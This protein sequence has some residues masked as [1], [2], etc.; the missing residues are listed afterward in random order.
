M[1]KKSSRRFLSVLLSLALVIGIIPMTVFADNAE[2]VLVEYYLL[3]DTGDTAEKTCEVVTS[4]TLTLTQGSV[5]D[6]WYVV[7]SE[8]KLEINDRIEVKG[9]VNLVL[10]NT[11]DFCAFEGIHV[12]P[13]SSLTIYR[14]VGEGGYLTADSMSSVSSGCAGI[15]GNNEE[16]NGRITINGGTISV[17]GYEGGA[18]IGSGA[19][20]NDDSNGYQPITING[21]TISASGMYGGAGIGGGDK[22][23]VGGITINGGSVEAYGSTGAAGIGS[24]GASVSKVNIFINGGDVRAIGGVDG[25]GIGTGSE[26]VVGTI[27]INAGKVYAKGSD[28]GPGI[29]GY[30]FPEDASIYFGMGGKGVTVEAVGGGEGGAGVGTAAD[31][32]DCGFTCTIF[33]NADLTLIG[34]LG[35]AGLGGGYKTAV[36]L[37]WQL[38][39]SSSIQAKINAGSYGDTYAEAIGDGVDAGD[40]KLTVQYM[41]YCGVAVFDENGDPVLEENRNTA[42]SHRSVTLATCKHPDSVSYEDFVDESGFSWHNKILDCKYCD[43]YLSGSDYHLPHAFDPQTHTCEC[44]HKAYAV[45]VNGWSRDQWKVWNDETDPGYAAENAY[46]ILY[47]YVDGPEREIH[48]VSATYVD[49]EDGQ[50]KTLTEEDMIISDPYQVDGNHYAYPVRFMMPAADVSFEIYLVMNISFDTNGS[51]DEMEPLTI[52]QGSE[53]EL[54]DCTAEAPEGK[55]FQG[56]TVNGSDTVYASGTELTITEDVVLQAQWTDTVCYHTEFDY[57]ASENGHAKI[58]RSCGVQLG[59]EE[60]H[61][62]DAKDFVCDLCGEDVTHVFF[63]LENDT[64]AEIYKH[65]IIPRGGKVNRPQ[66]PEIDGKVFDKWINVSDGEPF[67]FNTEIDVVNIALAP[68]WDDAESVTMKSASVVFT[69]G[70]QLQFTMELSDSFLEDPNASIEFFKGETKI[71]PTSVSEEGNIRIYRV[72]VPILEF[73]DAVVVKVNPSGQHRAYFY[74]P[75]GETLYADNEFI[76]SMKLYVQDVITSDDTSESMKMLAAHVALYY[77]YAYHFFKGQYGQEGTHADPAIDNFA[78]TEEMLAAYG[79]KKLVTEAPGVVGTSL[80]V[81]FESDNTLRM[82]FKL[83]A[84][85]SPD[86]YTF[87]YSDG[88]NVYTVEPVSIGSNR[89]A[90]LVEDIA[91]PNLGY[92][93]QFTLT[94]KETQKTY[95]VSASVMSYCLLASEKGSEKM[96]GLAK[97]LYC[98]GEAAFAYF[99]SLGQ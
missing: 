57:V 81:L 34:G 66:D 68:I 28:Y 63:L 67:D 37:H 82:S 7:N 10:A 86:D 25:A 46:A 20:A 73:R 40:G 69:A 12:G 61:I 6:G 36:T 64:D 75:D 1:Q 78:V 43:Q 70:L 22:A 85:C 51:S 54:P 4:E 56:W 87:A 93:Y 97:A 18:G 76:Y 88:E 3:G 21:G 27:Q 90:I 29:G 84:G 89:W 33:D 14:A 52:D 95:V 74:H 24:G 50:V 77:Q 38:N 59:A 79:A 31:V 49:P 23:L 55:V 72:D 41:G 9:V 2:T 99:D 60:A 48:V 94:H 32:D 15:G 96:Q 83:D 5:T 39:P 80:N 45:S 30:V 16:L 47:P 91:A 17:R 71:E 58:C 62:D 44:G 53:F 19:D 13:E 42:F 26:G 98:Y 11:G 65:V 92:M 8:V 35:A